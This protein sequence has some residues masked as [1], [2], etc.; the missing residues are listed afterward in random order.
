MAR[1][2]LYISFILVKLALTD[3]NA[4]KYSFQ[5]TFPE[6]G[7]QK[8]LRDFSEW[9]RR[10]PAEGWD[11]W[12]EAHCMRL[13]GYKGLSFQ[14]HQLWNSTVVRSKSVWGIVK[15]LCDFEIAHSLLSPASGDTG[16]LA[17]SILARIL[18][19]GTNWPQVSGD[20]G[21]QERRRSS[22]AQP[23]VMAQNSDSISDS[24][25]M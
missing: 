24:D 14:A 19:G 12:A 15:A 7:T 3:D 25:S 22:P 5:I 8:S 1:Q 23:A 9:N 11:I 18:W 16:R 10:G 13:R 6:T 20:S 17:V 21:P 2:H 4:I